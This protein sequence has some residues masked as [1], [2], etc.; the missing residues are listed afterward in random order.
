MAG[1]GGIISLLLIIGSIEA[2]VERENFHQFNFK[3]SQGEG[4][5]K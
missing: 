3:T 5:G 1:S 4:N 2:Q